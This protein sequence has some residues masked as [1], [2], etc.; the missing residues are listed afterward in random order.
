[1]RSRD[2]LSVESLVPSWAHALDVDGFMDRLT[3]L[4]EV[5][6]RRMQEASDEGKVLRFVGR[7]DAQEATVGL[8]AY[9]P[10]HPLAS[11]QG[12]GN[13]VTIF[14]DRY[15]SLPLVIQGHGAGTDVTAAGVFA[16]LLRLVKS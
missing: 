6:A 4:D 11:V 9:A 10:D 14:S 7:I 8:Q 13:C 3:E 5:W 12:T 2:E 16:D 15:A 1:M